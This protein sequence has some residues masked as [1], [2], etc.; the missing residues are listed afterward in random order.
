MKD[1]KLR[2]TEYGTGIA[3]PDSGLP[4]PHSAFRTP[5]SAYFVRDNGVGFD[6]AYA[7]KLFA[8]FQRL[9]SQHEFPGTG[10]GLAIAQR[11][12]T[13]HGGRI[14]VEAEANRGA[15]FYF[16]LGS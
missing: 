8:P 4:T 14:W 12:V 3:A 9:H 15:T 6:M 13:R 11:I 16:T 2:K 5:Q 10:I 7:D 1:E